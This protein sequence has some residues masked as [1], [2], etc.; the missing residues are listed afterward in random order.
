MLTSFTPKRGLKNRHVQSILASSRLRVPFIRRRARHLFESGSEWLIDAGDGVRLHAVYA[1]H[2]ERSVAGQSDAGLVIL[3]HGWEGCHDSVYLQS[4]A[5]A[6]YASGHDVLRLNLRDHGPSHHLN[7]GLFHAQRL[8]E[9]QQAVERVIEQ[10]DHAWYG[11]V[12][13]SLGGN[14]VLRLA[15]QWKESLDSLRHVIA[16][17]PVYDP[18]STFRAMR[19]GPGIYTRYFMKKWKR[20]LHR[21]R[22]AF[23]DL[24]AEQD[25][26]S[27][28][29]LA[30]M[31]DYLVERFTPFESSAAYFKSYTLSAEMLENIR[32]RTDILVARDDPVIPFE[33]ARL[34]STPMLQTH[35]SEF[36]GHCGF[37]SNYRFE[38]EVDAFLVQ[39][40]GA[41]AAKRH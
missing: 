14:F 29:D 23:P 32:I 5:A 20:S 26:D 4:A 3:I 40:F 35:V 2:S 16:V 24:F 17:C 18:V 31:T 15:A 7:K 21:K 27:L 33:S 37:I 30:S 34:V 6:L 8:N 41:D 28:A 10:T 13:F 22:L 9:V 1:R 36:G 11:L 19:E 39:C 38:S 25:I 12:G